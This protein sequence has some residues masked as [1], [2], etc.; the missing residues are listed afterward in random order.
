MSTPPGIDLPRVTMHELR[1]IIQ[2]L[3]ELDAALSPADNRD[4]YR[5]DV[6]LSRAMEKASYLLALWEDPS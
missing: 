4:D 2:H 6:A 1:A 5:A 3:K